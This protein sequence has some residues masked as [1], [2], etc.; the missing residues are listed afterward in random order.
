MSPTRSQLS[1][2]G[3]AFADEKI[4]VTERVE[5]I[6]ENGDI[7]FFFFGG[8]RRKK[9]REREGEGEKEWKRETER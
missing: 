4:Y 7:F 3:E 9:E 1:H 8:E 2:P 5:I 6:V